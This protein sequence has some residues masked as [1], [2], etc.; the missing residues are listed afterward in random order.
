[1]NAVCFGAGQCFHSLDAGDA[2]QAVG[3]LATWRCRYRSWCLYKRQGRWEKERGVTQEMGGEK[4]NGRRD[5]G[6][7]PSLVNHKGQTRGGGTGGGGGRTAGSP[8]TSRGDSRKPIQPTT[9]MGRRS[10]EYD[11]ALWQSDRKKQQGQG[12]CWCRGRSRAS[13]G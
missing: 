9:G 2:I 5:K 3:R 7:F 11:Q 8:Y 12:R 13:V 6:P 10:G 4:Q 1:M